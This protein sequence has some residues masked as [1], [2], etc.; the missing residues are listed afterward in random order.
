MSKVSMVFVDWGSSSFRAFLLSP[1]GDLLDQI[2]SD[3]GVFQVDDYEGIL[4]RHC[5]KWLEAHGKLPVILAG[6]IGSRNGWLETPYLPCPASLNDLSKELHT[7]PNRRGLDIRITSGVEGAGFYGLHDVMRGEELQIFGA[8]DEL[9][10][11]DA[12]LCLPGTH[13]KWCRVSGGQISSVTSYMTG[14]LYALLRNNSSIGRLIEADDY[15]EANFLAGLAAVRANPHLSNLL[16]SVRASSLLGNL[17]ASSSASYLSGILIG[18]ELVAA[19]EFMSDSESVLI[20]GNRRLVDRYSLGLEK[21]GKT[22]Q[23][24]EG[25]HAFLTGTKALMNE[26]TLA[27]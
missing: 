25:D 10:L 9:E 12:L 2:H 16:F 17:A 1:N 11:D 4:A 3:D 23:T 14:E 6:T 8:V 15:E 26:I 18:A 20:V 27:L 7:V 19:T 22:A 5:Q 24:M 13:S 21:L